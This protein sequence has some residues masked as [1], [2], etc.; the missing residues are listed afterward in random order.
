ML[1]AKALSFMHWQRKIIGPAL[2]PADFSRPYVQCKPDD[3]RRYPRLRCKGLASIRCLETG[4][5][6]TGTLR[7]LGVTGCCI[8]MSEASRD[9]AGKVIE[10]SLTLNGARLRMAGV[11]RNMRRGRLAGIEFVDVSSRRAG[12]IKHLVN[13]IARRGLGLH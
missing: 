3:Q 7:D 6:T 5:S 12:Q 13:E 11:V 2:S 4:I 10:I 9:L 1:V 8:E